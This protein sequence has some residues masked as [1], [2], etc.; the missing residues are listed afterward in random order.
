[1]KL[2]N[3]TG[4]LT[5]AFTLFSVFI[6]EN[7]SADENK[8]GNIMK[9]NKTAE[10]NYKE[11]FPENITKLNETDPEIFEVIN[12]FAFD[13]VAGNVKLDKKTRLMVILASTISCQAISEYKV[14]LEGAL[15]VGVTPVEIKE[16]VYHAIPYVGFSKVYDFI[17]VTNEVLLSRGIKLP[18]EGQSTTNADNRFEKG[19]AV[20]K[21]IFGEVIDKMRENAP[22]ELVHIQ[23]FLSANCFG[24]YYTRNGLDVKERE[25]I[26][27]TLLLS[28]GGC[29]PQLKGHIMGN[30]KVGNDRSVLIDTVTQLVPYI[31]YPRSLNAISAINEMT[32]K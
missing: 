29:E 21:G 22:Q 30:L 1:M 6:T 27:F 5:I 10:K 28:L 7:L 4:V 12:N 8:K 3:F 2:N 19:L 31:G 11:V 18:L 13:D 23:D 15:N 20:Q 9:L 17:L 24:D 25:L 32:K 16:L 26:T 14:M